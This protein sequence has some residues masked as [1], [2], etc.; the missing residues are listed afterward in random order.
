MTT[1]NGKTS[2]V[3]REFKNCIKED[4]ENN[5]YKH[6]IAIGA[7]KLLCPDVEN[8]KDE[9]KLRNGFDQRNDRTAISLEIISCNDKF[10]EGC[11]KPS[12]IS[13]LLESI[14]ITQYLVIGDI[15]FEN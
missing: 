5:G 4:F 8:L 7:S 12:E 15:D 1:K 3:I 9:Y 10:T 2:N 14:Y 13:K 6:D 11:K